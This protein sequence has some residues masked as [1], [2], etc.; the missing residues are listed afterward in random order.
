MAY[1]LFLSLIFNAIALSL[2]ATE[3]GLEWQLRQAVK[4]D[5]VHSSRIEIVGFKLHKKVP[6]S[7]VLMGFQPRPL[8]G[9]VSFE[10]A[11]EEKGIPQKTFG[12]AI[13][14]VEQPVPI[15]IKDIQKGESFDAQNISWVSREISKFSQ[16]SIVSD[17]SLLDDKV[18]KG[19]IR[20]GTIVQKVLIE[21]PAQ[22]DRGDLI[23]LF[24]EN[25]HLKITARMKALERGRTG[26]W[27][28]VEN[29]KTKRVVRGK[30]V[31]PGRVSIQ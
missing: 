30:V 29:E 16:N 4:K 7:A 19:F 31:G 25:P 17:E 24:L 15:A 26:D 11:W 28:R 27:I 9:A 20:S 13:I 3:G 22:I 12:T 23:D 2:P 5:W 8:L 10:L 14:K 21:T 18:A 6:D 1:L